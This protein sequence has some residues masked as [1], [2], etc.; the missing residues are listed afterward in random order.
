MCNI[1]KVFVLIPYTLSISLIVTILFRFMN[2]KFKYVFF[3]QAKFSV[4]ELCD[5]N[6]LLRKSLV[7]SYKIRPPRVIV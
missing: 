7:G 6:L 3:Y 4:T 1:V 5:Y 2:L